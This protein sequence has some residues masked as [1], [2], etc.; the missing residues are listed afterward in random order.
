[1]IWGEIGKRGIGVSG[2]TVSKKK[3]TKKFLKNNEIKH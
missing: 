1:M 2:Q 3:L